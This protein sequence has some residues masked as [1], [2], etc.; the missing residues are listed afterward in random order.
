MVR[1]EKKRKKIVKYILGHV[2]ARVLDG[3]AEKNM[4]HIHLR[5]Y[6]YVGSFTTYVQPIN[7]LVITKQTHGG[8][9]MMSALL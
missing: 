1:V 5:Q 2:C 3:V 9:E 8:R 4:L 6:A 7:L